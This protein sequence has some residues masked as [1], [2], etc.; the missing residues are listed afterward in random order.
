[1]LKSDAHVRIPSPMTAQYLIDFCRANGGS[2]GDHEVY[3]HVSDGAVTLCLVKRLV[4]R[5][6]GQPNG[7]VWATR[8]LPQLLDRE[9]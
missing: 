3:A 4:D 7:K 9:V 5:G 8:V 6:E 1:M 2:K